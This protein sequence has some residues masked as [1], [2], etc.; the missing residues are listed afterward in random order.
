MGQERF[1]F[2]AYTGLSPW[3]LFFEINRHQDLST[4]QK[5]LQIRHEMKIWRRGGD[6]NPRHP[7]GVKLLSR[8]P[9]SATPAPLRG[10]LATSVYRSRQQLSIAG[11]KTSLAVCSRDDEPLD[12]F[13]PRPHS[14]VL[15][16]N[17]ENFTI[18]L[19]DT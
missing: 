17:Y 7:F 10:P 3:C 6:S 14:R 18:F 16:P 1:P 5:R 15:G 11:P 19:P 2:H 8:Q 12:H 9:C 13:H 4:F